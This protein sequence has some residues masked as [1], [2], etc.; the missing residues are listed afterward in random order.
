M[1]GYYVDVDADSAEQAQELFE[2]GEFADSTPEPCGYCET[3]ADSIEVEQAENVIFVYKLLDKS[4]F[5]IVAQDDI[6]RAWI[7][8]YTGLENPN[9]FQVKGDRLEN[10]L[11][12]FEAV[13]GKVNR[14]T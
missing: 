5:H 12:D 1:T 8:E 7:V 2:R 6:S 11:A 4:G 10:V 14:S 9:D 13:G 3:Q